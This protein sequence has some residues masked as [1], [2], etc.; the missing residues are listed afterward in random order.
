[1]FH[2]IDLQQHLIWS[3]WGGHLGLAKK[4]MA[5]CHNLRFFSG[6][7]R[8]N[9]TEWNICD[10]NQQQFQEKYAQASLGFSLEVVWLKLVTDL[11]KEVRM[12]TR[13]TYCE[14]NGQSPERSRI[15]LDPSSLTFLKTK[16]MSIK[17]VSYKFSCKIISVLH[18]KI[19]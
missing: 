3:F 10:G 15:L 5:R 4:K 16:H 12:T 6:M 9:A 1:M 18:I 17:V 13:T 11:V 19:T 14:D 8:R 2:N 7:S